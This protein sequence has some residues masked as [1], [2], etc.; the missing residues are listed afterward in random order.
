MSAGAL[1]D[2]EREHE[3]QPTIGSAGSMWKNILV[4]LY[5]KHVPLRW[6]MPPYRTMVYTIMLS[7]AEAWMVKR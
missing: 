2:G 5:D 6:K 7:S 1:E 4:V 3:I